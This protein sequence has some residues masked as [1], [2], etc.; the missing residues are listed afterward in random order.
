MWRR[1]YG[2]GRQA[3]HAWLR[4]N[5]AEGLAGQIDKSSRPATCPHQ[6]APE[7]EASIVELNRLLP[8]W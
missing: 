2:V 5:A 7:I 4:R 6:M 8:G 3:V 1:R